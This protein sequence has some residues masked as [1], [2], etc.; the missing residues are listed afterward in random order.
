MTC[1]TASKEPRYIS[2]LHEKESIGF[3][4]VKQNPNPT[5]KTD[6]ILQWQDWIYI[7]FMVSPVSVKIIDVNNA[8]VDNIEHFRYK[9]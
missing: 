1:S 7:L 9:R 6:D 8:W 3:A 2:G 5:M 4:P